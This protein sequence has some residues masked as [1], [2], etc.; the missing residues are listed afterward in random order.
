MSKE[1]SIFCEHCS[2]IDRQI[3][4][5]SRFQIYEAGLLVVMVFSF[6]IC[7]DHLFL[8]QSFLTAI[9]MSVMLCRSVPD[10]QIHAYCPF[11][12]SFPFSGPYQLH[13]GFYWPVSHLSHAILVRTGGCR[14]FQ[15]FSMALR[16]H[17]SYF[18]VYKLL[19]VMMNEK[20]YRKWTRSRCFS[21]NIQE[22]LA[23]VFSLL[24]CLLLQIL[25]CS[26]WYRYDIL[27]ALLT[28]HI[29]AHKMMTCLNDFEDKVPLDFL[30]MDPISQEMANQLPINSSKIQRSQNPSCRLLDL[31]QERQN[32]IFSFL[33]GHKRV[34]VFHA[35]NHEH[36]RLAPVICNSSLTET[37]MCSW[38]QGP[39]IF[40][41]SIQRWHF[42]L[43]DYTKCHKVHKSCFGGDKLDLA[44]LRTCR[45]LSNPRRR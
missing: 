18:F 24:C 20:N 10:F 39:L 16:A 30:V 12:A 17:L 35:R 15:T 3:L 23:S 1:L 40:A 32:L 37:E 6:R 5:P 22:P 2:R 7:Y 13:V 41:C 42:R 34:H 33:L 8:L 29:W 26:G 14:R 28:N 44:A 36:G 43:V 27:Y 4:R 19:A 11:A 31:P 45:K 21:V 9:A 25:N 38:Y